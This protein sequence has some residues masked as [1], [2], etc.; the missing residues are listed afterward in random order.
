MPERFSKDTA[1]IIGRWLHW[2][3]AVLFL[4]MVVGT[5]IWTSYAES[6][7]QR[8][9]LDYWHISLGSIFVILLFFRIGWVILYPE[10]RTHFDSRWQA[11][12][13]RSNHW[14][15]YCLMIAMPLSGLVTQLFSG[16]PVSLFG[17]TLLVMPEA[18]FDINEGIFADDAAEYS[19]IL[20]L[21]LKWPIYTLLC[22]HILGA[23]TH[24]LK[25][26]LQRRSQ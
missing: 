8:E 1:Y 22:L 4:M 9:V 10:L 17:Q 11:I 23:L 26:A 3:A 12:A 20:H 15:L 19:E 7:E 13:A 25:S 16:D 24:W 6:R 2:L 14:A 21:F 18:V 5:D